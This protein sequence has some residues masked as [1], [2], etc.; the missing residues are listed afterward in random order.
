MIYCTGCCNYF[1][2]GEMHHCQRAGSTQYQ[3]LGGIQYQYT[4]SNQVTADNSLLVE[5]L[6][7]LKRIEETLKNK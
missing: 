7:T 5:I 1:Q 2:Q 4:Q 6:A 3:P